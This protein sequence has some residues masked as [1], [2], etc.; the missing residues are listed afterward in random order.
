MTLLEKLE[1]IKE[2]VGSKDPVG[3][4]LSGLFSDPDAVQ[5][6]GL[7]KLGLGKPSG[8]GM[9]GL[10]IYNLSANAYKARLTGNNTGTDM[11]IAVSPHSSY[12]IDDIEAPL[13]PELRAE[14]T[15]FTL[16][17]TGET[18]PKA[19]NRMVLQIAQVNQGEPDLLVMQSE[20]ESITMLGSSSY[21]IFLGG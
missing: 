9:F 21:R 10:S 1:T 5:E 12:T 7:T 2:K 3:D 6:G 13:I 4:F 14:A 8:Y 11:E 18:K 16:E 17:F 19:G 20:D 15:A